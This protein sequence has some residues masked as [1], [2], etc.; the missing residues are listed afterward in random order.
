MFIFVPLKKKRKEMMWLYAVAQER[1]S[2]RPLD[3]G[4]R[5]VKQTHKGPPNTD[6]DERAS[7]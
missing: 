6:L 1:G 2:A 4:E 7:S 5:K 3:K